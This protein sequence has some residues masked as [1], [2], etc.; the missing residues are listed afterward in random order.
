MEKNYLGDSR[1]CRK[2][3]GKCNEKFDAL[4]ANIII[5]TKLNLF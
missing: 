5:L 4:I 2:Q 1:L 3:F